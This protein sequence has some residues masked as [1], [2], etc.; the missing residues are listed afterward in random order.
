[1]G[2]SMPPSIFVVV[3]HLVLFA[4]HNSSY[5]IPFCFSMTLI[6]FRGFS[7]SPPP[8]KGNF[9]KYY[10]REMGFRHSFLFAEKEKKIT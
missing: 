4:V 5:W 2:H 8:P 3:F 6:R 10:Y 9:F 1:M 7:S